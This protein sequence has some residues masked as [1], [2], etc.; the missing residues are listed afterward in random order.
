MKSNVACVIL[1]Y[2][3]FNTTIGLLNHIKNF[4]SIQSIVLVDNRS[5]DGSYQKLCLLQTEKIHV[6]QSPRNG[7][8]GYGNNIGVKY[9]KNHLIAD[10]VLIANPDVFFEDDFVGHLLDTFIRHPKAAVASAPQSNS[11]DCAWKRMSI[12]KYVLATSLF[13]DEWMKIRCYPDHYFDGRAEVPVF[14]VPGS[15]LL[16]DVEKMNEI[17]GYDEEFFLFFEEQVLAEKFLDKGYE[18]WLNLEVSYV[19]NH[20][21]SMRKTYNRWSRQHSILLDSCMLFLKKYMHISRIQM[22]FTKIFFSYTR[23]EIFCYD[24]FRM[25]KPLRKYE[26]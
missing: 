25:I 14:A 10:Y 12:F 11:P 17:G 5:T 3:D 19:H 13:F 7:G 21:V 6:L 1:N 8:Y 20:H 15:L 9:A 4:K 18:T 2:N 23:F 24:I 26:K 16:V 22:I